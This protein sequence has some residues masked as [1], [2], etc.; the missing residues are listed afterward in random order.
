[1]DA[2]PT[3]KCKNVY[4]VLSLDESRLGGDE[5][6]CG[7]CKES[8]KCTSKAYVTDK[9]RTKIGQLMDFAV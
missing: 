2:E 1:M 7:T 3:E 6:L 5:G 8:I 9:Q 4:P